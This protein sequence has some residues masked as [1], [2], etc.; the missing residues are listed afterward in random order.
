MAWLVT[1][2]IRN[3]YP[4]TVS[5][6]VEYHVISNWQVL[7]WRNK[8]FTGLFWQSWWSS[9]TYRK[10]PCSSKGRRTKF[11]SFTEPTCCSCW[12][13][14]VL[15]IIG[16]EESGSCSCRFRYWRL[17]INWRGLG[18]LRSCCWCHTDVFTC[19]IYVCQIEDFDNIGYLTLG[20][21]SRTPCWWGRSHSTR[22]AHSA[23]P[24]SVCCWIAEGGNRCAKK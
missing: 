23:C 24:A 3:L 12:P 17:A 16:I 15:M 18:S 22:K 6:M 14:L 10:L 9:K 21:N 8:H 5:S 2:L 13:R 11:S 19:I 4:P 7:G 20:M 1:I